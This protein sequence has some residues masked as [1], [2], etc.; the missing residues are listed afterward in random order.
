LENQKNN[1]G[2]VALVIVLFL[3][4]LGL[5]GYIVY[6]KFYNTK[7]N[8]IVTTD[9]KDN[10]QNLYIDTEVSKETL[11][12]LYR[13]IGALPEEGEENVAPRHCLNAAVTNTT[14]LGTPHAQDVFSW[15]V[16]TYN[17]QANY[18]KYKDA[19]MYVDNGKLVVSAYNCA[20]CFTIE[21]SEVEKFKQLYYF[22]P[23]E[24]FNFI[25]DTIQNY[26]DIYAAV[27]SL[28]SPVQCAYNVKHNITKI[29]VKKGTEGETIYITD[30]Q[31]VTRYE[32]VDNNDV[33]QLTKQI[34]KYSFYK[35]N[36]NDT[37][38]L[39]HVFHHK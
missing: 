37:Y 1:G 25:T 34:I 29:D 30:E 14:Y 28:G 16:S 21:K 20:A 11:N 19:N 6:D 8:D 17:K 13:I 23:E 32:D 39:N 15:Y 22:G 24:E 2:L 35:K 10:P 3:L 38:G 33:S 27:H 12:E 7:D 31:V 26:D 18:E 9:D 36:G 4:V 5:G